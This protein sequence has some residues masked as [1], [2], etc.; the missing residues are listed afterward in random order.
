MTNSYLTILKQISKG[1]RLTIDTLDDQ[2]TTSPLPTEK[3]LKKIKKIRIKMQSKLIG[4]EDLIL[5]IIQDKYS[6]PAP[7]SE[8]Y[9]KAKKHAEKL[10]ELTAGSVR[11]GAALDAA[12]DI[13]SIWG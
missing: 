8:D 11:A 13:L 7:D 1:L 5:S 3:E 4:I 12:T 2:M 9:M 10:E 6:I